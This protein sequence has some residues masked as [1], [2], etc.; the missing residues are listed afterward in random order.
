MSFDFHDVER[1]QA[2]YPEHRIELRDGKLIVMSPSDFMTGAIGAQ[3]ITFLFTW[4][5]EHALGRV[6]GA[7]AGFL[8]P[9]GDLLS[10]KVSFVSRNRLKRLPRTYA[11]VVPEL[12][13]E[14]KS[15]TDRVRELEQKIALFI[16]QGV[17][18]G[19]LVDPDKLTI[20]VYR[21]DSLLEDAE[22]EEIIAPISILQNGETLTIP[23]LF[24][25]W[26]LPLEEL[27]A[28]KYE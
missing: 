8:M 19:L 2:L 1:L 12:I 23:D 7:K 22:G 15:S 26:E 27:W 9:N 6:F 13:V 20:R 14:I 10:P 17:Q 4:V 21:P 3:F 11:A 24:P 5:N 25:G 16:R 18:I 28:P